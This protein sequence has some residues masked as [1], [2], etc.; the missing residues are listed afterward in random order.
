M[1]TTAEQV[2]S[3]LEQRIAAGTYAAG[4]PAPSIAEIVNEF[5]V[6]PGTARRALTHLDARGLTIGGGQGRRRRIAGESSTD[7]LANPTEFLRSNITKGVFAPG[8]LLPSE[9]ELV[10]ATGFSRYA[11]R[12]AFSELE[13][14]GEV[15]NRAGRRRQVAG[16]AEQPDA[17]YEQIVVAIQ[18]DARQGRLVAGSRMQSEN[19]LCE[20]FGMSR[21][22]VRRALAELEAAGVFVRDAAGRRVVA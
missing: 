17:R 4:A 5:D 12:E 6:A 16:V 7:Q 11:V 22:T 13:R 19:Q 21:V 8:S 2:A 1:G 10:A 15:I 9:T 3:R 20:R 14:S 18:D